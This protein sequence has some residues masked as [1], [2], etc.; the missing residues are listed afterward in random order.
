MNEK[1]YF[2][3]DNVEYEGGYPQYLYRYRSIDINNIDRLI[4]FELKNENI[5]LAG[6]GDLNDPN[7][8]RFI[9]EFYKDRNEVLKYFDKH[10][11]KNI[12]S[13][14]KN[15][16]RDDYIKLCVEMVENG[17]YKVIGEV[18]KN[19]REKFGKIIRIACFTEKPLNLPMWA[20][21][22]KYVNNNE[23]IDRGGLCIKYEVGAGLKSLNLHPVVYTDEKPKVTISLEL[24]KFPLLNFYKKTKDWQ[25]EK[26]WRVL[27][28]LKDSIPSDSEIINH[29]KVSLKPTIS[30]VIFGDKTPN[31]IIENICSEVTKSNTNIIFRRLVWNDTD[32]ELKTEIITTSI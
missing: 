16:S 17:D 5:F 24:K 27:K 3:N 32:Q 10:M 22:A 6:M 21:Y 19:I 12:Q 8:G 14:S 7:E 31:D 26:E 18:P 28:A 15:I 11:P 13:I 29:S 25:Y 30:E 2:T 1:K 4:N 9:S 20:H 23:S